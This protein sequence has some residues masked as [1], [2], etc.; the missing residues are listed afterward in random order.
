VV[1]VGT[2]SAR[3]TRTGSD[4]GYEFN[5]LTADTLYTL[6]ARKNGYVAQ[7]VQSN[8]TTGNGTLVDF[9]LAKVANTWTVNGTVKD[10]DTNQPI[11]DADMVLSSPG[12]GIVLTTTANANGVYAFQNVPESDDYRL[13]MIPSG[14]LAAQSKNVAVD[15]NKQVDF[16]LSATTAVSGTVSW[17]NGGP[18]Y[19]FL[20]S[21]DGSVL[22]GYH[23]LD[24]TGSAFTF[25]GLVNGGT[26]RLVAAAD[27]KV[28]TTDVE[29][30]SSNNTLDLIN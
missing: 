12:K 6:S 16:T 30:P 19:V 22:I 23:K 3:V 28:E 7:Y 8:A 21:S 20:Y 17:N 18:A 4:G 2:N 29:A 27:G 13:F 14:D 1:A 24:S 10:A 11:T 9:D 26:Y 5:A 15:Q 25:S